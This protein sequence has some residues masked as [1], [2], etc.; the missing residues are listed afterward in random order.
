MSHLAVLGVLAAVWIIGRINWWLICWPDPVTAIYL[1]A[2]DGSD[3]PIM[4]VL[5]LKASQ[6]RAIT[7]PTLG[8]QAVQSDD[9]KLKSLIARY[10]PKEVQAA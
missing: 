1:V 6:S 2:E 10:L 8:V 7:D 3:P 5:G 9:T 4:E